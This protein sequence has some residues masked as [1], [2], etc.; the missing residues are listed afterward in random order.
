MCRLKRASCNI[1]EGSKGIP[2]LR[3]DEVR[4]FFYSML[5]DRFPTLFSTLIILNLLGSQS[6]FVP[7]YDVKVTAF[8]S[9]HHFKFL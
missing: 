6:N 5:K 8:L 9:S 1:K 2:L 4:F 7:L 3:N